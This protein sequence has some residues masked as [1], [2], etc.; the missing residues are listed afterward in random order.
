MF[1]LYKIL[2]TH[3]KKNLI[4]A[5]FNHH[6]REQCQQEEDYLIDL[7]K[8]EGIQVEIWEC[9][10]EKIKK[11]YPSKSFEELAREKRYQFFDALC[12]IHNAKKIFLAHHL[13]DRIETMMFHMLR[14][15]KLTWLINM[16]E[17]S[18]N[19]F[20]PLLGIE[21]KDILNYLEEYSLPY[22]EDESNAKNEHTR[23]F[24]RNQITPLF[25]KVHPENKKNLSHL[26][27]YFEDMKEYIDENVALFLWNTHDFL[28]KDFLLQSP[29]FQKEILRKIYFE[30]NNRSTIGLSEAN[31]SEVLRF[32]NEKN[33]KW[34]KEIHGLKLKKEKGIIYF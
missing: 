31:I 33:G 30:R 19:I 14:G 12:H 16:Q 2:E 15:T 13:D 21:K 27:E 3:Y 34:I 8:K 18:W 10:F 20:R 32:L 28:L 7:W 17:I 9:D 26:L 24:I 11:L 25:E 5:Y 1:L 23:N 22:F 4:V 6:T 29:F